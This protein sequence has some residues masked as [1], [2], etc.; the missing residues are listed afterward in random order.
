MA[1]TQEPNMLKTNASRRTPKA[2]YVPVTIPVAQGTPG[3]AMVKFS[4]VRQL[5]LQPGEVDSVLPRSRL[6]PAK[7]MRL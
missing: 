2:T 1:S 6:Q 4:F 3:R 5:S 7:P